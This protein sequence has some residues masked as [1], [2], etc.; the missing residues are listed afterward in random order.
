MVRRACAKLGL[1]I[2]SNLRESEIMKRWAIYIAAA[3]GFAAYGAASNVDRDNSGQIVG[4][5]TVDAFAV[6]VGDCFND[7]S[8]LSDEISSLQGVPCS[9]P[10]DNEAFAVFDVTVNS[11][12]EGEAMADLAYASCHEHFEG[13]VG[14]DYDSSSLDIFSIFPSVESW[15]QDDREVICAVFD[16]NAQK[17]TGSAKGSGL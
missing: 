5:G 17:L 9:E 15:K 1:D 4:E 13:F 2:F 10:H 16:V 6:R 12:P 3:L 14:R 11:Y 8:S 7:P